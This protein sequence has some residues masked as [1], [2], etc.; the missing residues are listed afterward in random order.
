[1]AGDDQCNNIVVIAL[2]DTQV[3]LAALVDSDAQKRQKSHKSTTNRIESVEHRLYPSER[4]QGKSIRK[5]LEQLSR[6]RAVHFAT[7]LQVGR[8]TTRHRPQDAIY[9]GLKSRVNRGQWPDC[10]KVCSEG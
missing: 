5:C 1:M 4:I 3:D 7:N 2:F 9:L 10:P 6:L 8:L